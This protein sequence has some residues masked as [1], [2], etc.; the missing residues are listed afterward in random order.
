MYVRTEE[1]SGL[2]CTAPCTMV[3]SV[4]GIYQYST[5]YPHVLLSVPNFK[6]TPTDQSSSYVS[7]LLS[8][9]TPSAPYVRVRVCLPFFLRVDIRRNKCPWRFFNLIKLRMERYKLCCHQTTIRRYCANSVVLHIVI[10]Q[11]PGMA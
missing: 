5:L 4:L 8:A 2:S 7:L 9:W 10:H 3:S 6:F 11:V 1:V